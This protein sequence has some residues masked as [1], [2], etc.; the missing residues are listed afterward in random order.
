MEKLMNYAEIDDFICQ[1]NRELSSLERT[2]KLLATVEHSLRQSL[3]QIKKSDDKSKRK[4]AA[5]IDDSY[6]TDVLALDDS[7]HVRTMALCNPA[8]S[9]AILKKI[10]EDS[11]KDK[12]TLMIIAHNPNTSAETLNLLFTYGGDSEEICSAI[13]ANPNCNEVLRFKIEDREK[14]RID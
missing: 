2:D 3:E 9:S 5:T 1:L 11:L 8:T 4:L 6:Y 12:F 7:F 10:A 14:Q 13:L